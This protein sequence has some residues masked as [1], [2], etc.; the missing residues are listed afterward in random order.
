VPVFRSADLVNWEQ[1]GNCLTRKSQLDLEG[2]AASKGIYA[3]A[4]RYHDGLFYMVTT[5]T[6]KI[7]NF[8]VTAADPAGEWSDPVLVEQAGIDPSLFWDDDGTCYFVSNAKSKDDPGFLEGG[9]EKAAEAFRAASLKKEP[10]GF[11]MAPMDTKTGKFLAPA[12]PVW[13]GTGGS[14]PEAPHIY[15]RNGW[16]YQIV[17]EGGTE[18]GHMVTIARSRNLFGPYEPCPHNPILTHRH[19]KG[20]MIQGTGHGD[21]IEDHNGGW[22][23]VFLGFRQ[24]SQYFHHLGRETFLAPVDWVD[25]WPVVNRGREIELVM[26]AD[27]P[28]SGTQRPRP[29]PDTN[30][31]D[32]LPMQWVHLRNPRMEDYGFSDGLR[33]RGSRYNLSDVANPT[34]AAT[35][36]TDLKCSASIELRF[37]PAAENEEAGISVFY[38]FDAHYDI[39]L[40]RREGKRVVILRKVVG[41]IAHIA[42]MAEVK[43]SG[44]TL[45]ISSDKDEYRF[46]VVDEG[47]TLELGGGLT[48]HVSTEAHILG[49]TG[50]FFA[51][52]ASGNGKDCESWASFT[53]FRYTGYDRE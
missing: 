36:Q 4:I 52:Y 42:N 46:S 9:G 3:P 47:N 6:T 35:R 41:D 50:V 37:D 33:L 13:G 24:T 11:L 45:Q 30:F 8:Y 28:G 34:F 15:K 43:G 1:I 53:N 16:Y 19:L 32:G 39:A 44:V 29:S 51:L 21:M 14:S 5:N 48:R 20:R 17:A 7:G 40:T 26:E 10:P 18:L 25:D 27:R 31:A 38:K 49:F 12:R 23:M 2:I 22:W